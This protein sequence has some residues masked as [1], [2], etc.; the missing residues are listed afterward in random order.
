MKNGWKFTDD[1]GSF[2][3][4]NPQQSS[5][6]Y[7][8]LANE[9]G[10][11]ASITPTLAGDSKTGQNSF[12]LQ[13]V[14]AEDLEGIKGGRN[15]WVHVPG[16]GAWSAAGSSAAQQAQRFDQDEAVRVEGGFLWHRLTRESAALGLRAQTTSFVPDGQTKMELMRVRLTNT[17]A[18]PLTYTATAA[19]PVYGRSA[20]NVRDHRHVT[21]LLGRTRVLPDGVDLCPAMTFDERGHRPNA[22]HYVVLGAEG[23]GALPSGIFADKEDF[24]GEGGSME[25]PRAV[26]ESRVSTDRPGDAIDGFEIVGAPRFAEK[27]LQPGQSADYIVAMVVAASDQEIG[28]ARQALSAASF[29][30]L[31]EQ[32]QAFWAA[33]LGRIAFHSGDTQFNR[34]MRWITLQPVLRRIY[35]CSFLPHHDYGKGGRGW[36]D[37]WQDCL[38]LL[39]LEPQ[40]ARGLLWNNFGGVRIDGTNATIIGSQP[41]EFIA[42]RNNISRVWSDHGAWPLFT[43]LLY[44]DNTGDT[45]FLFEKQTYF[46]DRLALRAKAQDELWTPEQGNRVLTDGGAVYEGTVLEHLLLQNATAFFHVGEHGNICLENADWN[47]ALDMAPDRG[48]TVAFTAFYAGNLLSLAALLR[49]LAGRGVACVEVAQEMASLFDTLGESVDYASPAAKRQRLAAYY[50]ATR[51]VLSGRKA[52]LDT[53]WLAADLEKKGDQLSEHIR[54]REWLPGGWFNGYYDNAGAPLE[55]TGADGVRMT[56]TGQVFA[57]MMDVASD[58]Q[59]ALAADSVRTHLRDPKLGGYRLNTNFHEVKLDMGRCFGFAYGH[60]ENGA[61]FSHMAVMYASALYRR[62]RAADGWDVVGGLYALSADF[63]K[64]RIYPG[65]P[66]YF[67]PKGRGLYHYLTGSASWYLL[68]LHNDVFGV[69]GRMGD[70]ELRPQLLAAQFDANG[71]AAVDTVFAGRA[72]RVEYRNP[73]VLEAG[74]YTIAGV[75]LDGMPLPGTGPAVCID[76]HVL[77]SL[78]EAQPHTISVELSEK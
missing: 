17:G 3:L 54:T 36:R 19:I 53:L 33:K 42:D 8:P 57:L 39:L 67:N 69:R 21:G 26:V 27:T 10:M 63:E 22:V 30:R 58:E 29:Q 47:D 74:Q 72:L 76:R 48:E 70:L 32:S 13:P 34:W 4:E 55:G 16:K 18:T 62:G 40:S 52:L 68:V 6:L 28:L 71:V 45:G 5:A 25:W 66:E 31:F 14:S 12:L 20:D 75:L 73:R 11:M 23:D 59:V 77:S 1:A 56:L 41:G 46:K 49:T 15:F 35:G 9:A 65:I 43:T 44:L 51:H 2:A 37:L 24:I 7:F 60:K 38:A 50:D 78:D 61:I 64:A